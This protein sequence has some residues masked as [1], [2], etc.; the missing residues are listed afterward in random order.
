MTVEEMASTM[1]DEYCDGGFD[2]DTSMTF[3]EIFRKIYIDAVTATV[4]VYEP[5]EELEE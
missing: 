4:A 1:F 5:E 3:D 2:F